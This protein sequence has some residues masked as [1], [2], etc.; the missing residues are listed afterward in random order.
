MTSKLVAALAAAATVAVLGVLAGP[1]SADPGALKILVAEA[2][3][4]PYHA[5]TI[6]AEIAAQPGVAQV[7]YFDLESGTPTV[8][9]MTAYDA[10]VVSDDNY[11]ADADALGDNLAEYEDRQG[12]VIATTFAWQNS[13]DKIG[14]LWDQYSPYQPAPDTGHW[15]LDT[16]GAFDA[17]SPLM[18]GVS[19]LLAYFRDDLVL[20]PGATEVAKWSDGAGAVAYLGRAVAITA[21]V[22]SDDYGPGQGWSGDFAKI[23]V[24]AANW[25]GR[26]RLT[27]TRAGT[28]A[29]GVSS[30]PAGIDCG[31]A[32]SAVYDK[33]ATVALTAA[34]TGGSSF[35][36]WSGDCAGS[37]ATCTVT[38]D[39]ARNVTATF[40][41]PPPP[42]VKSG[43][44]NFKLLDKLIS[45]NLKTGKG[46]ARM[47]CTNVAGDQCVFS[48][49][50]QVPAGAKAAKKRL[51]KIGTVKGTVA[52]GT[53]GKVTVVLTRKG[54][55][56]LAKGRRHRLAATAVGTSKNHAG[57]A[58]A[59]K[60]KLTL[61]GT[62]APKR[63]SH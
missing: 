47:S 62:H 41:P 52:G 1:A 4:D 56:L 61:R 15:G 10:V 54:R 60:Q 7:D 36:G 19:T 44:A 30:G 9:Q 22:G 32:C 3:N 18:R 63:R 49:A 57:V 2:D 43:T 38:M 53:T 20:N 37:A 26:Q 17:T 45:I 12:V 34:P 46:S 40:N 25:L 21:Y 24:N 48:L 16:L 11:P 31:S 51:L 58:T 14:G 29:G 50:L 39:A 5:D 6:R 33:G 27:V 8:D 23:I 59:V 55:A 28:G 35:A 13:L 42:P